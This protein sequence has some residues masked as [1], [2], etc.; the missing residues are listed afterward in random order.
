MN[1]L[2]ENLEDTSIEKHVPLIK[3]KRVIIGRINHPM[4]EKHYIE[5]IEATDGKQI[6]K[7]FLDPKDNP[8]A[9]FNFNPISARAYCNI[10]GLWKSE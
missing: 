7:I 6:S 2:K 3:E 9:T 1:L 8:E 5:W 10:H 4:E